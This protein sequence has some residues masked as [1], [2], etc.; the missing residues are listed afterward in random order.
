[1][2]CCVPQILAMMNSTV[3]HFQHEKSNTLSGGKNDFTEHLTQVSVFQ[4]LQQL[5][6]ITVSEHHLIV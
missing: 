3:G 5:Q 6:T 1:M 2:I 4:V